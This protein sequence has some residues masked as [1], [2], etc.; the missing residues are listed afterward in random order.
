MYYNKIF[1][2]SACVKLTDS[3]F[4]D[5]TIEYDPDPP[6]YGGIAR[7]QCNQ[8]FQ[9]EGPSSLECTT[10]GAWSGDLPTCSFIGEII[11]LS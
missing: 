11:G 5:G 9:L 3:D 4:A 6:V 1:F 7:F 8:G 10:T 2:L